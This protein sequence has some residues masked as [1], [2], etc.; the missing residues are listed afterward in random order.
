[1][2]EVKLNR[3]MRPKPG[4]A[5][6]SSIRD[7]MPASVERVDR[8][9]FLFMETRQPEEQFAQCMTC[10]NFINDKKL[11]KL[12]SETDVVTKGDSCGF[13]LP[14]ENATGATPVAIVSPDEAGFVSRKVR[15]EHCK[16]FDP[17]NEPRTHCDL[18]T[19]LNLILPDVF[20][21]DRYVDEDDCCNANTSG[22]RSPSVFE[23]FGPIKHDNLGEPV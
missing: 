3:I 16:F 12:F 11:C 18:Y 8:S 7:K 23:P 1:M 19:Q 10:A 2:T 13:Y 5:G 17:T 22:E 4:L 14:G 20:D 6:P 15:C 9:A 21:L